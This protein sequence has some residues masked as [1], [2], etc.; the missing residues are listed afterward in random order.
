[1]QLVAWAAGDKEKLASLINWLKIWNAELE[2]MLPG[3]NARLDGPQSGLNGAELQWYLLL[4][5]SSFSQPISLSEA[6]QQER[7]L[8]RS[9]RTEDDSALAGGYGLADGR[10]LFQS[11]ANKPQLEYCL[12]YLVKVLQTMVKAGDGQGH[13]D[14]NTAGDYVILICS[15]WTATASFDRIGL[16]LRLPMQIHPQ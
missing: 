3:G 13:P 8:V 7:N 14:K 1:M 2:E 12:D 9:S 11:E 6:C 5:K 4:S 16:F 10:D 15:G